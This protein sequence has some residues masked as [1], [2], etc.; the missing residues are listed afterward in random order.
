MINRASI[1]KQLQDGLNSVFG[2]EYKQYPELWR[3]FTTLSK[4]SRKAYIEDVLMTGLGAA[5]AKE[6]GA[7]FSYGTAS[8]GYVARAIFETIGLGVKITEEAQEDSLYLDLAAKMTRALARS[9][10]YTKN[11]KG[12]NLLN[13]GFS[14]N[15]PDGV[16]LFSNSHPHKDGGTGDNLV[17]ADL[18]ET[19]LEDALILAGQMVDDAGLPAMITVKSLVVP[20]ELQF[21]AKKI[22]GTPTEFDTANN[23][24]NVLHKEGLIG[25]LSVNRFLTDTDSWHLI[26]DAPDGLKCVD[27]IAL[28]TKVTYDDETNNLRITSRTR[29]VFYYANYRGAI[30][31]AG[32]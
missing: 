10:A 24:I 14:T 18:S 26:T 29:Y 4:E 20:T 9:H 2:L 30:G 17:A 13:N 12:A 23:T 6:E 22:I 27:R 31:S 7:G 5:S 15:G 11:V 28:K 25:K 16:P 1:A 3:D 8:E 19:S 21:L 32:L